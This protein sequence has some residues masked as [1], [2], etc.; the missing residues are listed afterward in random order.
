MGE[1]T[2]SA[3][4]NIVGVFRDHD[5]VADALRLLREA[6]FTEGEVSVLARD[7]ASPE[8]AGPEDAFEASAEAGKG[9]AKGAALGMTAGGLAGLVGGLIAFAIP[10]VGPALGA[11]IMA[12][13][14]ASGAVAGAT[15]GAMWGGMEK[16]WDMQYRDEVVGGA[17]LVGVHVDEPERADRAKEV[18]AKAG[19]ERVDQFDAHGEV[20]R[21][22]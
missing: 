20:I 4:N 22:S 19:A 8:T 21:E 5:S 17:V 15:A 18:L 16:V 10:G 12:A 7:D 9:V 6:G 13:G 11:G 14:L 2:T 1:T 3:A